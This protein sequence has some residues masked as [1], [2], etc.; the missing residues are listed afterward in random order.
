[1]IADLGQDLGGFVER[2]AHYTRIAALDVTNEDRGAPLDGVTPCLV[3]GFSGGDIALYL[4]ARERAEADLRSGHGLHDLSIPADSDRGD[5]LV[6]ASGEP[7]EHLHGACGVLGLAEHV[8]VEHDFGVGAE[9]RALGELA[10]LHPLPADL[11]LRARDPLDI[12]RGGLGV[13]RLLDD[14]VFGKP[15]D[16]RDAMAMLAR[17]AGRTHQVMTAVALRVRDATQFELSVSKVTMN[18]LTQAQ[19][20]RYVATGEP[21]DKAG[22]YAVQGRAA[23]FIERLEGSYTGVVG[24][25]LCETATLLARAGFPIV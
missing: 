22:A 9:N 3:E 14:E 21:L 24:L 16:A 12:V 20:E 7:F 23:A 11:R 18:L 10:L 1:M 15:R 25:P 13:A 5:H 4:V 8:A 17:L 2:Q 19:I 6:R